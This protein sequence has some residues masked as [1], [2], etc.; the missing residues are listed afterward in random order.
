MRRSRSATTL[1]ALDAEGLGRRRP[2]DAAQAGRHADARGGR[3]LGG[4]VGAANT[5]LFGERRPMARRQHRRARAWSRCCAPAEPRRRRQ[6]ARR[7]SSVPGRPLARRSPRCAR[8]GY[9]SAVVFARRPEA[10]GRRSESLASAVGID[11]RGAAVVRSSA[12]AGVAPL[13]DRHDARRR[14][15]RARGRSVSAPR[16]VL[17]DVIYSPWPTRWHRPGRAAGAGSIGGLELLVEQAV[18]QVRLMTGQTPPVEA[19]RQA[20]YAA[21][22]LRADRLALAD[23]LHRS[24]EETAWPLGWASTASAGSAATTSG[25]SWPA[26]TTSR[27]SPTTTSPTP[28]RSRT[29]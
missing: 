16:G 27:S 13:V 29:C 11:A 28:R 25:R 8:S 20:G 9:R 22:A 1:T 6:R 14:H 12:A 18:E 3:G 4:L 7:A 24:H 10:A 23:D 26:G 17:F 2:D 15:R 21:L 5:V 19:M